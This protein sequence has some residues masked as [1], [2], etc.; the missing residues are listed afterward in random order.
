[1]TDEI[2]ISLTEDEVAY[3]NYLVERGPYRDVS[4]VFQHALR[5]LRLQ[6]ETPEEYLSFRLTG[7][8]KGPFVLRAGAYD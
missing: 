5:V 8:S 6:R 1:M 7:R 4:G 2:P 3:A